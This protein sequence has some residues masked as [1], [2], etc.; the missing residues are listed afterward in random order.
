[1]RRWSFGRR[2]RC[3]SEGEKLPVQSVVFLD[4]SAKNQILGV[5]GDL[6]RDVREYR[7]EL[8]TLRREIVLL[9][10]KL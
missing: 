6:Q 10:C 9:S 8:E 4:A 2:E 3:P 1:M 5:L 7:G